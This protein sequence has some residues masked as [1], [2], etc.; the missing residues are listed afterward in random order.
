[1]CARPRRANGIVNRRRAVLCADPIHGEWPFIYIRT[2]TYIYGWK[3][4]SVSSQLIQ[5]DAISGNAVF[6]PGL[7]DCVQYT[8]AEEK[9]TSVLC[10]S[11]IYILYAF[12]ADAGLIAT[13]QELALVF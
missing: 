4:K 6:S 8:Y 1:M 5:F 11:R 10:R 3:T 9:L 12:E 13:R 2:R 7:S